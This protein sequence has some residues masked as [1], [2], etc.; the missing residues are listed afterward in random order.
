MKKLKIVFSKGKKTYDI[1]YIVADNPVADLWSNKIK[2]LRN[3]DIDPVETSGFKFNSLEVYH[4]KFCLEAEV[5]FKKVDYNLQKDLNY[6]HE[7]YEK[8][9]DRLSIKKNNKYYLIFKCFRTKFFIITKH[10]IF[11]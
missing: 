4:K 2:H 8:H 1:N 7:L 9:H 10:T 11:L 5:E 6:L 3:S